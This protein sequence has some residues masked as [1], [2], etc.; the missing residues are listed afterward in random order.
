MNFKGHLT[1]GV[2]AG[3]AV[4]GIAHYTGC[5]SLDGNAIDY[6]LREP[7]HFKGD[8]AALTG[9]FFLTLFMSLFPDLDKTSISQRWFFRV[10]FLALVVV[11]LIDQLMLFTII[12][13]F[14][15]AP[16]LHKHRGWTHS[17]LTPFIV[18]FFI[19]VLFEYFN[20]HTSMIR[21]FSLDR[22]FVLFENYWIFFFGCILGHYTHLALD[23]RK[24]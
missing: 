6:F 20:I 7:L 19:A 1:G 10:I 9:L 23:L 12:T 16:L 17:W 3:I 22:I 14:A 2:A 5:Y 21:H 4:I 13:F 24:S 11:L 15:I 18:S 8:I